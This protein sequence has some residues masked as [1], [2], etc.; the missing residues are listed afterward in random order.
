MR[1]NNSI[2]RNYILSFLLKKKDGYDLSFF[3][4]LYC[5][6][7]EIYFDFTFVIVPGFKFFKWIQLNVK[8]KR[9]IYIYFLIKT[10]YATLYKLI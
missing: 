7:F 2:K 8:I 3:K 10:H 5:F 6:M 9:F 1:Y 4:F